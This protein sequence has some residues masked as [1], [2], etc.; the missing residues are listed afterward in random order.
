MAPMTVPFNDLRPRFAA[1]PAGYRAAVERVFASARYVLG[2]E[3]EAFETEFADYLGI[4]HV[5]GVANG[6]DAIELALRA[7]GI[8]PGDEVI[9]VAH[10][11]VATVCAIER[12]GARPVFVD[13]RADDYTIDPRAI[14]AAITRRTRAIA[15]VH[16]YGQPAKLKELRAVADRNRLLLIEDCAQAHGARY[17]GRLVGTFGHLAAFSFYPTKNLGAFGDGGAVVTS[18]PALAGRVR[19]LRNYGQADR[20]RHEDAGG[21]NSRL[22]ELQA[23]LLRVGLRRLADDNAERQRLADRYLSRLRVP[24]LPCSMPGTDHVYHLFV[25][26]DP[27]REAFRDGLRRRGVETLVHY[28]I[29]VHLQPAYAHLGG[30][31][32]DLPETE[33]AAREVVSLPLYPG[34]TNE[35]QDAVIAAVNAAAVEERG[36]AKGRTA[37]RVSV[38]S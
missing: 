27:N 12:A 16:L 5:V 32:G 4:G 28:P 6:T 10:T 26:R 25:V 24:A 8:G 38:P 35:Q 3:V 37:A 11:A 2:P 22:D 15:A 9:T 7:A 31:P 14:P 34:L 1:D 33:R 20:Y 19:R 36:T 18:D 13:V 21:F 30:K 29:P 17:G 23:A